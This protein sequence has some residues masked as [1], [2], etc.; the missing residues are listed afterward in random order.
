MSELTFLTRDRC[1]LCV[2]ALPLVE[3]RARR[4][5]HALLVIDVDSDPALRE[6]YGD[7]VPVV[8]RD[9]AEVLAGAF[10][11]REIRRALP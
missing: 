8:L 3:K 9:G 1:M 11:P 7:R 5:R 6:R 2:D 10:T 4:R